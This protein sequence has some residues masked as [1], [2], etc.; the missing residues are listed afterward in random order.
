M[1]KKLPKIGIGV[2][3]KKNGEILLGIRRNS[4]DAGTW[5]FPGGHLEFGETIEGC[6]LR[7]LKE[8]AGISVKN[9]RLGT[10][11]NDIFPEDDKHYVTLYVVCDYESGE[12][13]VLEPEKCEKWG[14]FK[15]NELPQPLFTP[16]KNLI[17]RE[18]KL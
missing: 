2:I 11:T 9:L 10:F 8:E 5:S 17:K 18:Y 6:A 14:W 1:D 13:E 15:W 12:P 3:V 16:I 4:H 7:E